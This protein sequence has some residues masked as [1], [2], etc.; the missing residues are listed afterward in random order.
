[1]SASKAA[2]KMHTDSREH[3]RAVYEWTDD[4][5]PG[6][7]AYPCDSGP[8]KWRADHC[9]RVFSRDD[10]LSFLRSRVTG[11]QDQQEALLRRS[12]GEKRIPLDP[13]Q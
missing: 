5:P 2:F 12:D 4:S 9:D 6:Q 1:V 10:S 8:V 3:G 7:D 13:K 11:L